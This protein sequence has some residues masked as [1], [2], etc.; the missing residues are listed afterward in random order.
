[1]TFEGACAPCHGMQGE[2]IIGPP[3]KGNATLA[4]PKQLAA[5]LANGKGKMP[6]VGKDWTPHELPS[7]V[8]Y[9]RKEFVSGG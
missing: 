7:L 8:T 2:G 5:L 9:L 4:N 6:P 3:L 1:M